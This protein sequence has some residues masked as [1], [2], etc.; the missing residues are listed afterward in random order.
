[1]DRPKCDDKVAGENELSI[2]SA[3]VGLRVVTDL[4]V[5]VG[6]LKEQANDC[7]LPS[8]GQPH[9]ALVCGTVSLLAAG[10]RSDY[11]GYKWLRRAEAAARALRGRLD[12]VD[13]WLRAADDSAARERTVE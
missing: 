3:G 8:L 13:G 1:M 9:Y 2:L 10:R 4:K 5:V 6:Q 12:V 11:M 7:S